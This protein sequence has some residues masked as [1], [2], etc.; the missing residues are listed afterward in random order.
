MDNQDK[1]VYK[2]QI[3][4]GTKPIQ[5]R[6]FASGDVNYVFAACDRPTVIY[7]QNRKLVYSNLNEGE[8][9][10]FLGR[11]GGEPAAA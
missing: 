7:S 6:T 1:Q 11:A 4:L 2:K 5:L 10:G 3:Q 9:R 8:V